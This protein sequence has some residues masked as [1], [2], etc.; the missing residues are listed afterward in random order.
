MKYN[1]IKRKMSEKSKGDHDKI[2]LDE[3]KVEKNSEEQITSISKKSAKNKFITKLKGF[4][5][6][7]S[8]GKYDKPLDFEGE[9]A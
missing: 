5:K 6:S 7:I 2:H 4:F 3:E 8:F 9:N 1:Y